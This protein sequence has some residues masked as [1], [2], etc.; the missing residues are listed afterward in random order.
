MNR[1]ASI[2]ELQEKYQEHLTEQIYAH[3]FDFN[4]ELIIY[5]PYGIVPL[6]AMICMKNDK[7]GLMSIALSD[8][9]GVTYFEY[10]YLI[11]SGVNQIPI[12]S[13]INAEPTLVE[14]YLNGE[15]IF[16]T[17]LYANVEGTPAI[18]MLGKGMSG[19]LTVF[20]PA[21]D[22][23]MPVAVNDQGKI[24]WA[25][26]RPLSQQMHFFPDGKII[27][28]APVQLAPPYSGTAFWI[29]DGCGKVYKELRFDEGFSGDFVVLSEREI[30]CIVQGKGYGTVRD[31]LA[32]I[33]LE[34]GKVTDY[35]W[36]RE[37]VE[38]G[39]GSKGQ[40]G[41]DWFQGNSLRLDRE[42]G[43]LYWTGIAQ[44]VILVI[45][46]KS[47]EVIQGIGSSLCMKDHVPHKII[48]VG[49]LEEPYGVE[50]CGEGILFLNAHRFPEGNKREV[51]PYSLHF[52]NINTC[53][54]ETFNVNPSQECSPVLNDVR[55][56]DLDQWLVH[57]GCLMHDQEKIPGIFFSDN[58][59]KDISSKGYYMY[60]DE[61]KATYLIDTYIMRMAAWQGN[62]QVKAL[63]PEGVKGEWTLLPEVDIDLVIVDEE[64][65]GD[66]PIHFCFD[67]SRLYICGTFYKGEMCVVQL[68][69]GDKQHQFFLQTNR[70]PYGS[71][72]LYTYGDDMSRKLYA[73]IPIMQL[74]PGEWHIYIVID[75]VRYRTG[76]VL[77]R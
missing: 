49:I 37:Y 3:N 32:W 55:K 66:L 61:K 40:S 12:Y 53:Q 44:N 36:A 2:F 47:H 77:I 76:N 46:A 42:R 25:C 68:R 71:E 50:P 56:I 64:E 30:V 8:E 39:K 14:G 70:K 24:C 74:S 19:A 54:L 9:A 11:E 20:V 7:S 22:S 34:S 41:T 72:W 27:C 23:A 18:E 67:D 15:K 13:L 57:T 58:S 10:D 69:Q 16:S 6:S 38:Y 65:L 29:M 48:N 62:F 43:L 17:V 31:G 63:N 21:D 1:I 60:K 73:G 35:L 75:E 26:N 51:K 5:N 33:D 4:N 45:D 52:F 59:T 28:G